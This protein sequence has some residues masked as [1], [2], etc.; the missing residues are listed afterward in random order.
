MRGGVMNSLVFITKVIMALLC[1]IIVS[2]TITILSPILIPYIIID[3]V[4]RMSRQ[5]RIEEQLWNQ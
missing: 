4:I 5:A 3:W 1:L 2:I